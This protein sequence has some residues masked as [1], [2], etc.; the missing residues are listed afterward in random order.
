MKGMH[1]DC[2]W[3]LGRFVGQEEGSGGGP[4]HVQTGCL[5]ILNTFNKGL[6]ISAGKTPFP[7][8]ASLVESVFFIFNIFN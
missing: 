8:I 3:L 5:H 6:I 1:A 2:C 7:Y 4:V